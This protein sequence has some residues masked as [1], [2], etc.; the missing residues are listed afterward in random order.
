MQELSETWKGSNG[1][2]EVHVARVG[3]HGLGKDCDLNG[4]RI[5]VLL[6]SGLQGWGEADGAECGILQR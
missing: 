4:V 2:R 3:F 1:G 6:G 5:C